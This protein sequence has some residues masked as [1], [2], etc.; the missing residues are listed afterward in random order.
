MKNIRD[1]MDGKFTD[2]TKPEYYGTVAGSDGKWN[3]YGGAFANTDWF[4]SS[5][6]TG[7]LLRNIILA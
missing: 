2:P 4:Q 7:C 1:Y 3:N 5:I 6:V